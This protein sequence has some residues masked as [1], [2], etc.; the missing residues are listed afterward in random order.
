[1]SFDEAAAVCNRFILAHALSAI[2]Y[3]SRLNQRVLI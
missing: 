3:K 1:M 2:D